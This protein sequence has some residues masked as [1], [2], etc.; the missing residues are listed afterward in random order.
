M[1]SSVLAKMA[2]EVSANTAKFGAALSQANKQ[3][4]AFQKTILKLGSALGVTFGSQQV[5]NGLKYGI[6]VMAEFEKQMS[7]VKAITGAVGGELK[8]LEN[9]ALELGRST[10]FAASQVAGLQIEYGRLGFSTS[11]ILA[12]TK[13]TI[14]LATA[15]G[16]N[17]SRSAE[18]AGSTLRAFGLDASQSGRV[19]DVMASSFNKSAL[20]LDSFADGIKYVAPVAKATNVSLEETTALLSVLADAGIKGSQAGTSLRRIFTLLTKDGRPFADRLQELADKGITLA[21]A[22]DEVGLYAQTALLVIAEQNEKVKELTKTYQAASGEAQK[23]ADIMRDNLA[24]DFD[25]LTAAIDGSILSMKNY[26]L[27]VLRE[28]TQAATNYVSSGFSGVNNNKELFQT[29]NLVPMI[30]A[31]QKYGHAYQGVIDIAKKG[32]IDITEE[33]FKKLTETF[34][35]TETQA[36]KLRKT[37]F[38][39]GGGV[40]VQRNLEP[41]DASASGRGKD[42]NDHRAKTPPELRNIEFL[43]GKIKDLNESIK[44]STSSGVIGGYQ[45]QIADLEVEISKLTGEYSEFEKVRRLS[46]LSREQ[47]AKGKTG[48]R[49]VDDMPDDLKV[50]GQMTPAQMEA[51]GVTDNYKLL[52]PTAEGLAEAYEH[53]AGA[54]KKSADAVKK[55]NK[56]N[57]KAF[58]TQVR[59]LDNIGNAITQS[60]QAGDSWEEAFARV[61]ASIIDQLEAIAL[62]WVVRNAAEMANPYLVAAAIAVGFAAVKGAFGTIYKGKS[63]SS[64]GGNSQPRMADVQ[65]GAISIDLTVNGVIKGAD[66]DLVLQKQRYNRSRNG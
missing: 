57:E 35:L 15:T 60:I 40:N 31:I 63:S 62:A 16:E 51:L 13:A 33:A 9:N 10:Q 25:K 6:G 61:A 2:V 34:K 7:T 50:P 26:F 45:K 52:I 47:E 65:S 12:T 44:Q 59:M 23:T 14:N 29:K 37:L 19:T 20:A 1:A 48:N 46:I 58:G 43:Q 41:G 22:N 64:G 24:G 36:F 18:I 17:L 55:H 54:A 49:L 53:V 39:I 21:D 4:L 11:E 8:S 5:F 32:E 38:D 27:P 3:S 30:E 56:E 42:P 66:L 28:I